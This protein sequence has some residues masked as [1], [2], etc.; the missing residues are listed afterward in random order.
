MVVKLK[1][2]LHDLLAELERV[3]AIYYAAKDRMNRLEIEIAAAR[4]R[5]PDGAESQEG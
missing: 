3:S 5:E 1:A 2:S 4:K